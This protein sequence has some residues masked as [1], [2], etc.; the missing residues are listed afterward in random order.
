MSKQRSEIMNVIRA[1][2]RHM[3]AEEIYLACREQGVKVSVATVYRNLGILAQE[4]QL[5]R[6]HVPGE[7]DRFD[8]TVKPH[9]HILCD[10]CGQLVDIALEDIQAELE[11]RLGMELTGYDLCLHYICPDCREKKASAVNRSVVRQKNC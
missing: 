9:S 3:T 1:S 4:G 5:R 2:G 8:F 7:S 11:Q 10:S 6:V